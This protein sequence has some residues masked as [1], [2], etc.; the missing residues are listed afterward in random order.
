MTTDRFI[1]ERHTDHAAY[2]YR[3]RDTVSD[4]TWGSGLLQHHAEMLALAGNAQT[5]AY[6][7]EDDGTYS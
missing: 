3:V 1:V 6:E 2:A 4:T 5:L 7:V